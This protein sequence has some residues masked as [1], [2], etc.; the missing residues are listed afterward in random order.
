MSNLDPTSRRE[1]VRVVQDPVVEQREVVRVVQDPVVE[2]RQV[3][4]EDVAASN[5]QG[6]YQLS[7]LIG[8]AF[9]VLEGLIGI[10]I[11]L[12]LM[13]ANPANAFARFIYDITSIF[14]APF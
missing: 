13:A 4:T 1:V 7:A 8:F 9:G 3:V 11:L 6:L 12:K 10:R 5:R 2:Q 14:L